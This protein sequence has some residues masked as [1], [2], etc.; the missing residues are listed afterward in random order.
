M[1]PSLFQ[2][3][4]AI[5]R[6]WTAGFYGAS[7]CLGVT[8][9]VC[10]A[11]NAYYFFVSVITGTLLA[12]AL[13]FLPWMLFWKIRVKINGGPFRVGDR[14]AII[15]GPHAGRIVEVYAVWSPRSEVKV[16]LGDTEK[17]NVSDV[18]S[19]TQVYRVPGGV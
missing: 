19:Y 9:A 16:T 4:F 11:P 18:F 14:V 8:F 3:L 5:R 2:K 15:S 7:T 6:F 13:V 1:K 17:K 12:A 10:V